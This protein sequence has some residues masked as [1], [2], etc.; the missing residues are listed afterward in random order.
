MNGAG[1]RAFSNTEHNIPTSEAESLRMALNSSRALVDSPPTSSYAWL[2]PA[3]MR[4]TE[5][6]YVQ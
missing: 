5:I 6:Q 2:C 1:W 4:A 3:A